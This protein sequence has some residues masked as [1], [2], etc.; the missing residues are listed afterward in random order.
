MRQMMVAIENPASLRDGINFEPALQR[1]IGLCLLKCLHDIGV[2]TTDI[3]NAANDV[4]QRILDRSPLV[5]PIRREAQMRICPS[6]CDF[7]IIEFP[8]SSVIGSRN[9]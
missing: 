1:V 5:R 9:C 6:G 2:I 7:T 3:D 4:G 8:A